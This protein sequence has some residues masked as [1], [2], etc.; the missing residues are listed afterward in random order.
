[1]A[2]S[3]QKLS[4]SIPTIRWNKIGSIIGLE[5]DISNNEVSLERTAEEF[6]DVSF[7]T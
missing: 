7:D 6:K 1:M 2:H 3:F 4:S 5:A